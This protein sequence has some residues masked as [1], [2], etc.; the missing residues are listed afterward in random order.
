MIL[1]R[2]PRAA[3][4][5]LQMF[6]VRTE[7]PFSSYL[8]EFRDVVA[9]TVGKAPLPGPI[10]RNCDRV[11]SNSYGPVISDVYAYA[12]PRRLWD[13]GE[14]QLFIIDNVDRVH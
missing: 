10:R 1:P 14:T 12:V 11:D 9:S 8:R 7:T 6:G 2:T 3:L 4:E 13:E 5:T